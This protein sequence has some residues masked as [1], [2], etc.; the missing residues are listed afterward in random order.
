MVQWVKD[1]VLSLLWLG[2]LVW[3]GF[4]PW[5]RNFCVLQAWPKGKK[6]KMSLSR[7]ENYIF[8]IRVAQ[9]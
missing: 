3:C 9:E 5:P 1:P 4:G 7:V 2:S 6:K 8:Q